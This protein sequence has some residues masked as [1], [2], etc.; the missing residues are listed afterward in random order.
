MKPLLLLLAALTVLAADRNA[1]LDRYIAAPDPHYKYEL[2]KTVPGQ[3]YTS[4]IIDLTSQQWR[5]ES[6]V[7]RPIWKHWLTIVRPDDAK[8]PN[9]MLLIAGGSVDQKAPAA[10]TRDLVDAAMVSHS[11]IAELRGIPNEPLIFSD[12]KRTR[13]EDQ[14]IAYSWV[15]FLKTGDE[16]WPLRMPMT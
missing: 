7:N 8:G 10:A 13:T 5:S 11:V 15:K 6:E 9:A 3:G 1:P 14:I 12:E 4:Y 2:V 16:S